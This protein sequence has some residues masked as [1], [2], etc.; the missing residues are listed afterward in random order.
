[1]VQ[2]SKMKC[3]SGRSGLIRYGPARK[4]YIAMAALKSNTAKGT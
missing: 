2:S 4:R 3:L 1:M